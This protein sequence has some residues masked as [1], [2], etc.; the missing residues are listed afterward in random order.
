MPGYRKGAAIA[1]Q[2]LY[3]VF[4]KD[5]VMQLVYRLMVPSIVV[6]YTQMNPN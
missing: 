3:Q 6:S 2:H 4:G 1:A 5:T